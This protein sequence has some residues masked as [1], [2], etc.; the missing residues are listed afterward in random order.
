[1]KLKS[2]K[3]LRWI[4]VFSCGPK[5]RETVKRSG[6]IRRKFVGGELIAKSSSEPIRS[7]KEF[8]AVKIPQKT[9]SFDF[10][11]YICE[12]PTELQNLVFIPDTLWFF[13]QIWTVFFRATKFLNIA[14]LPPFLLLHYLS[15]RGLF[16]K[17]YS[18]YWVIPVHMFPIFEVTYIFQGKRSLA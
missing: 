8:K 7:L 9:L 4:D 2:L 6:R 1:M 13:C 18:N 14:I 16:D 3:F 17:H 5:W 10:I 12:F 15:T 11:S